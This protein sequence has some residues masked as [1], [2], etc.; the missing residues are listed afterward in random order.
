MYFVIKQIII[1]PV[2]LNYGFLSRKTCFWSNII[3]DAYSVSV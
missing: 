1:R 3:M 2:I